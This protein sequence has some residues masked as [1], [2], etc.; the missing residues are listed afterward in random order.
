M[1]RLAPQ[2]KI[3][4]AFV[5]VLCVVATDRDRFEAFGFYLLVLLA[6]WSLARIPPGWFAPRALIELPFV[7]LALLLPFVGTG[8]RTNVLGI[9]LSIE[10]TLAGWN[11]LAKGTLGVLV[12]LT[13]TATTTRAD[14][15][16]G[17]RRLH[18]PRSCTTIA[19]LM[20]RYAE[21]LVAQARTMRIARICRGHDPRF[22]WQAGATARGIG[23]LFLRGYERGERVHTAMLAR[24]WTGAMPELRTDS[25]SVRGW[26][27]G[28]TP[29]MCCA[30]GLAVTLWTG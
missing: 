3:V 26:L 8:Q 13:L 1:H 25:V 15:L 23:V 20:L 6:V 10:G 29:A 17:L 19:G 18:L 14:M 12:A 4:C 21:I 2:V 27:L 30:L 16:L 28:L 7:L 5:A 9:S 24:G 11:I 22:L